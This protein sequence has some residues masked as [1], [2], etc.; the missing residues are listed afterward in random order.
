MLVLYYWWEH[1]RFATL[2]S[3]EESEKKVFTREKNEKQNSQPSNRSR[4][5]HIYFK[6]TLTSGLV[7]QGFCL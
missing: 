5:Y 6:S 7:L 1:F 3:F 2:Y 4:K